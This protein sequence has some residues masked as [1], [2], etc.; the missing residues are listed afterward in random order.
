MH[1]TSVLANA[2]QQTVA[3]NACS[4]RSSNGYLTLRCMADERQGGE[5]NILMSITP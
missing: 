2:W 3:Y 5:V 4:G 1:I